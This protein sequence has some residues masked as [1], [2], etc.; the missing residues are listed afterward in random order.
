MFLKHTKICLHNDEIDIVWNLG[1]SQESIVIAFAKDG[2][3]GTSGYLTRSGSGSGSGGCSRRRRC[4][5][6]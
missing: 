4:C 6:A 2:R 1:Q 3:N 5:D